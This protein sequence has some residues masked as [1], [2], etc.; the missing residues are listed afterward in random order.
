MCFS[1]STWVSYA[2]S[3][4]LFLLLFFHMPICLFCFFLILL[5]YFVP[6]IHLRSLRR[7][8]KYM[9]S[10]K[11]GCGEELGGVWIGETVIRIY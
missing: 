9:D 8:R 5:S 7:D 4:A 1:V 3:L 6:Y 10:D 2:F 11:R